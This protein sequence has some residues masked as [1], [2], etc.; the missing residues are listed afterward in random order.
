MKCLGLML[1]LCAAATIAVAAIIPVP[2]NVNS[3][4]F[5][6]LALI[7]TNGVLV[8]NLVYAEPVS[9]GTRTF[10]WDG[11]TDLG[12]PAGAGIYTTR[13]V[14]FTNGPKTDYVMK[15]GTSGN[16]PWR[17]RNLTGDWGGDLGGPSTI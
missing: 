13:A 12:L 3:T 9:T 5:V 14:F 16:P 2:V 15:V 10:F 8:R 11:T 6:S 4:G 7:N 17:R 1:W